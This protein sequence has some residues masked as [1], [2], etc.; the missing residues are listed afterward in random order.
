MSD[1]PVGPEDIRAAAETFRELGPDYHS[2]VIASFIERID[3]EVDARV[4]ARLA[5]LQA[6]PP[7][8]KRLAWL[9]ERPLRASLAGGAAAVVLLA[10]VAAVSGTHS[11]AVAHVQLRRLGN[12]GP[13]ILRGG[14]VV[15]RG[16]VLVEPNGTR[17]VI[18]PHA[19]PFPPAP[20]N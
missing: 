11:G 19:V 5:E 1:S 9:R 13:D 16:Q 7:A 8:K 6:T 17:V 18:P 3:R 10:G 15:I 4:E 2:A 14:K 20:P 12:P